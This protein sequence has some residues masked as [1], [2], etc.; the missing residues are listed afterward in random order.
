MNLKCEIPIV[1]KHETGNDIYVVSFSV[2]N[3]SFIYDIE[4]KKLNKFYSDIIKE[5]KDQ[6]II[7][8]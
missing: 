5:E 1:I 2:E 4:L 6:N 7:K 8:L 3:N